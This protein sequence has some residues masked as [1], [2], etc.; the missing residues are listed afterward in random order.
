MRVGQDPKWNNTSKETIQN[1]APARTVSAKPWVVQW[2]NP[3]STSH[4]WSPPNCKPTRAI[5]T[6]NLVTGLSSAI[7]MLPSS[8][9]SLAWFTR[10]GKNQTLKSTALQEFESRTTSW[11]NVY[12]IWWSQYRYASA[13]YKSLGLVERLPCSMVPELWIVLVPIEIRIVPRI[14]TATATVTTNTSA[15]T[16][17]PNR[18]NS[19][20]FIVNR[21][22]RTFG[23]AWP[24][25]HT[26]TTQRMIIKICKESTRMYAKDCQ[27][28]SIP[29]LSSCICF[30]CHLRCVKGQ[31]WRKSRN[32][33]EP[34]HLKH[35]AW[36]RKHLH[37]I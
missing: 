25:T 3:C 8:Q 10:T 26:S 33:T 12:R 7:P 16:R 9:Q 1:S 5:V 20:W 11:P 4:T 35:L 31:N 21:F 13:S 22:V 18:W 37:W 14:R 19:G 30:F 36:C 6:G 2:S 24:H 17:A 15:T 23:Q 32:I 29:G 28:I 34:K 27:S